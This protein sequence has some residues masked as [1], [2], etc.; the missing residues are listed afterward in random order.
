M[1]HSDVR[2]FE[3]MHFLNAYHKNIILWFSQ[4]TFYAPD[5]KT[6]LTLHVFVSI[7]LL[8]GEWWG[9]LFN[10]PQLYILK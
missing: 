2:T 6:A 10:L 4:G 1:P 5:W 3:I 9:I 7:C 8:C